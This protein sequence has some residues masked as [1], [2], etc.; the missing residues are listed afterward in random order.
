MTTNTTQFPKRLCKGAEVRT[1]HSYYGNACVTIGREAAEHSGRSHCVSRGVHSSTV[2]GAGQSASF[3]F[4]AH[5]IDC[6]G[7]LCR[8]GVAR[9]G[10]DTG[11][12]HTG[13]SA[14][15]MADVG[16]SIG[17]GFVS[18]ASITLSEHPTTGCRR[19][20]TASARPSIPLLARLSRSVTDTSN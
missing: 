13:R 9:S 6:L 2:H 19:R 16:S 1:G 7:S 3:R 15:Y 8:M 12:E 11:S 5:R 17:V 4:N 18:S 20:Q 14:C 10:Q